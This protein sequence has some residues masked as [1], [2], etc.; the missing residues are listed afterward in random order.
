[1]P[2]TVNWTINVQ[3]PTGPR[4]AQS[5]ALQVDAYDK[6]EVSVADGVD[7]L[8]VQ[9]QPGGAGQVQLLVISTTRTSDD[10]SYK[11]N[12]AGADPITLDQPVHAYFGAGP[13]GLLDPA[14][15]PNTLFFTNASGG[16]ATVQVL[17]GRKAI[18]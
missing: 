9:L 14:A 6:V 4:V 1:M 10:L 5:G 8:E 11:V 13:V 17:V 2:E 15:G 7:D 12:D 3:V 16:P 18:P